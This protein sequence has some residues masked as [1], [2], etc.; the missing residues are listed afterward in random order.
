MKLYW[1]VPLLVAL[2]ACAPSTTTPSTVQ[3]KIDG[4][5][6][7][8]PSLVGLSWVYLF[9]NER[10]DSPPFT[11]SIVQPSTFQNQPTLTYRLTGRG[12]DWRLYRQVSD[13][14]V[15]LLGYEDVLSSGVVTYDPPLQEYPASNQLAPGFSWGGTTLVE[16]YLV[17]PSGQRQQIARA[18][19]EYK[20][21]VIETVRRQVGTE[22]FDVFR[23]ELSTTTRS[24]EGN[25]TDRYEIWFTPRV[26]EVRTQD[27]LI[28]VNRNF[29]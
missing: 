28:L 12:R 10:S 8:Y 1:A 13:A 14:G 20:Y 15:F 24:A 23:I 25:R 11:L 4:T 27:G 6:G 18:T 19:L 16:G 29:K 5:V 22:T 3:T 7:F 9:Q 21:T 26:G 2:A 17:P